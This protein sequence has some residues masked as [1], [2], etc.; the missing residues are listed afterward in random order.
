VTCVSLRVNF[1]SAPIMGGLI[2]G[3]FGMEGTG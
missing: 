1:V 3:D 2:S